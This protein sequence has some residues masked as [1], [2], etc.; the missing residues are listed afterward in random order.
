MILDQYAHDRVAYLNV[1]TTH[2]NLTYK[3]VMLPV[4]VGN[5][6]YKQKLFNFFVNGSTGR[7][8]G[9]T[10]KSAL[11]IALTVLFI[12]A[13]VAGIVLFIMNGQG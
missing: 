10:P 3:Y 12:V 11:K 8:N 6:N 7:V 5:F 1:S 2:E 13:I 4:Y 9:K